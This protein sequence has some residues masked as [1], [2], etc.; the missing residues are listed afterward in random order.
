M[1]KLLG[2]AVLAFVALGL[3]TLHKG[4]VGVDRAAF[5]VLDPVVTAKGRDV[6]R[7]VTEIGSYPV[8]VLV[9]L[10][11]AML[12]A[13]SGRTDT[14]LALAVGV[15]LL[16]LAVTATKQIWDRPRPVGRFYDPHGHSFPSGHSAYVITWIA[17]AAA[18]GGR[19]LI[20]AALSVAVAIG[21]CR[22]YLHVHYLTDVLG[23]YALGVAIFAPVLVRNRR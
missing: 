2:P 5:D 19:R 22:L 13:R 9:A 12:A 14:A 18:V 10:V 16:I 11:G 6:V 21:V 7:V 23:G 4:P 1:L 8:V 3:L 15:V 20:V 17:A